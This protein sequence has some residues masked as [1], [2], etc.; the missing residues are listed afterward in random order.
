MGKTIKEEQENE[1]KENHANVNEQKES[2][3]RKM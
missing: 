2:S 1:E 3:K